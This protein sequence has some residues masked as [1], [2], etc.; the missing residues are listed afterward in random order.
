M[1]SAHTRTST[2]VTGLADLTGDGTGPRP[3]KTAM[4][5]AT[6]VNILRLSFRAGQSM[7]DHRAGRPILVLGKVGEV[8]FTVGDENVTVRPGSA[9]HVETGVTHALTAV[10][11][12]VVTL[13][14]LEDIAETG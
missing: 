3:D 9:V 12:A 4:A 6:G 11:D 13:L 5:R 7:A 10:T 14:I 2:T 8:Q 1:S